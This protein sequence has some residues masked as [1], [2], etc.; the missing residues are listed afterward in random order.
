MFRVCVL[1]LLTGLLVLSGGSV[2]QDAKSKEEPK[3]SVTKA[4]P[5]GRVKGK[6][7]ANWGRIGLA[8]SQV[9]TIYRIQNKYNDEID[10][11]EARIKELRAARD[12]ESKEVLTPDQQKRLEDILLKK[13]K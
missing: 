2:G 9:Q 12:K 5:S 13:R 7:P 3:K 10:K 8:D 11:L 4:D 1:A 6:L